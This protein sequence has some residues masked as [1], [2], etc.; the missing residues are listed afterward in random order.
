MEFVITLM[1]NT[2]AILQQL[3]FDKSKKKGKDRPITDHEDP[4]EK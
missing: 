1:N 4:E 3:K 2:A